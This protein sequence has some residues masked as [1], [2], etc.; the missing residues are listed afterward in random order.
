MT[1]FN[2][3]TVSIDVTVAIC[4][5]IDT[6]TLSEIENPQKIVLNVDGL[7][8][9]AEQPS[10]LGLI[11]QKYVS[12]LSSIVVVYEFVATVALSTIAVKLTSV[13]IWISYKVAPLEFV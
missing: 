8:N 4:V 10:F 13:A 9:T 7:L 11:R 5:G 12:K 2:G 6:G 3:S 1:L